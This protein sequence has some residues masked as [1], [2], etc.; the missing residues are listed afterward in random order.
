MPAYLTLA[1]PESGYPAH[2]PPLVP[3]V[4]VATGRLFVRSSRP[5]LSLGVSLSAG[6]GVSNQVSHAACLRQ[7]SPRP[8]GFIGGG[9][10]VVLLHCCISVRRAEAL[11][12]DGFDEDALVA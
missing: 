10:V 4:G 12:R 2:R 11:V 9:V 1:T 3:S 5:P 6:A 8:D 7:P